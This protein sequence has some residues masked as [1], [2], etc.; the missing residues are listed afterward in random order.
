MA[1][2]QAVSGLS[3]AVAMVDCSSNGGTSGFVQSQTPTGG[4][5]VNTPA[6]VTLNVCSQSTSTTSTS[7]TTTS[8]TAAGPPT[9]PG[10]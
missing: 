7:T 10:P 4:S 1:A 8:T 2:V 9:P 3:A 5:T 6:T